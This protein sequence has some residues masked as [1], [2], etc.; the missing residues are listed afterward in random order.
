MSQLG[1]SG[2]LLDPPNTLVSILNSP[3]LN[4]SS[5]SHCS[6]CGHCTR[7]MIEDEMANVRVGKS[8]QQRAGSARGMGVRRGRGV[9]AT[10]RGAAAERLQTEW[11][12]SK[13][14]RAMQKSTALR[15]WTLLFDKALTV[16]LIVHLITTTPSN[17]HWANHIYSLR[18]HSNLQLVALLVTQSR[19]LKFVDGI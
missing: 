10:A 5:P 17:H 3:T 1:H 13:H 14:W 7:H 18:E 9:H 6:H 12:K 8:E 11:T 19:F 4:W 2:T 15:V 16:I